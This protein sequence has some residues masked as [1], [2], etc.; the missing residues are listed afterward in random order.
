VGQGTC[1]VTASQAGNDTFAPARDVKKSI[2][3]IK[4]AQTITF[5]APASIAPGEGTTSLVATASSGLTVSF[6]SSTPLICTISGSTLT[7]VGQ[8]TCSVTASQAGNDTFAPARDVKKS[9]RIIK[10]AQTITFNPPAS[11]ALSA[12]TLAL[13]ASSTSLLSVSFVVAD[14]SVCTVAGSTLTL[15]KVGTC[16]ITASQAG[17]DTFAPAREVR[18]SIRVVTG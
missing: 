10:N 7:P 11:I 8:G 16:S 4:S 18:K 9:I 15:I 6:A 1:S 2:R 12:G 17:N 13:S 14:P 5:N 3:I